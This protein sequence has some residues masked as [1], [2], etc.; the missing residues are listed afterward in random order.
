MLYCILQ[1]AE[2]NRVE[3]MALCSRIYAHTVATTTVT[4]TIEFECIDDNDDYD[5]IAIVYM[6][7]G[8]FRKIVVLFQLFFEFSI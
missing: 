1:Q 5:G 7:H 3:L 6:A 2:P 4:V 8:T